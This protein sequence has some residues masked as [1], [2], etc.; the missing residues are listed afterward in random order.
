M[1]RG[2]TEN[3]IIEMVKESSKNMSE[4]YKKDFINYRGKTIDTNKEY[5]EVVSKWLIE[6]I[7]LLNKIEKITRFSSYKVDT[8]DGIPDNDNSNREEE[9]L[10]ME[11]FRIKEFPIVGKI[12]DYQTPLKNKRSDRAGKIDIISIDENK[13]V[14]ILELKRED[15]KETM[16]RCVLEAYTYF[17][18]I[19]TEKFLDDF[20]LPTD[21]II[22]ASPLVFFGGYQ[23]K[24]M[25]DIDNCKYLKELMN[26][27]DIVPFYIKKQNNYNI[28]KG[29]IIL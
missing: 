20:K 25:Q 2:Y 7:Y 4:F 11:L 17:K 3:Q 21:S 14:H 22:E 19:D 6:N 23:H 29:W 28:I 16:L 10:A 27:L 8:H 12:I 26:K 24:E 1:G 9:L 15:S 18:T 5:T 13:T